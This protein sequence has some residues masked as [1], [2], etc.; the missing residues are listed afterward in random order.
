MTEA[1]NFSLFVHVI[2]F[3]TGL[4]RRQIERERNS[5][6]ADLDLLDFCHFC[7]LAVR[8]KIFEFQLIA[9]KEI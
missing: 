5:S 7:G 8:L 1:I 4:R 2:L 3:T 9:V 6:G